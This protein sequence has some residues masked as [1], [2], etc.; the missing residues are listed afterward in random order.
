MGDHNDGRWEHERYCQAVESEIARIVEVVEG[1]DPAT[2]VPTCPEWT[3]AALVKHLGGTHRWAEHMVRHRT[4]E[5]VSF[6]DVRLDLPDDEADYPAWLAAGAGPL[7]ATLRATGAETPVWSFGVDQHA[8]FWARRMCHETLVHRADAELALGGEPEID[9]ET[10]IDG[11]NELLTILSVSH[12]HASRLRELDRAGET[13]HL[14]ATD[15]AGEWIITPGPE[16]FTWEHG[17]GKGAVAVRAAASDLLLLVYGRLKPVD[18]R[19][20]VFGD[21]SLL[22]GWLDTT[23]F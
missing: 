6:R 20:T 4:P 17:H 18:G 9:P 15:V 23:A 7:V 2:P 13:L 21:A 16:E 8:R 1:A 12:R 3:I 11:I 14:H 5:R 22:Q 10:A 19:V